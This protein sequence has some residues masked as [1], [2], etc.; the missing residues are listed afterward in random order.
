M[1]LIEVQSPRGRRF[2][3]DGV[4]ISRERCRDL[5]ARHDQDSFATRITGD[6]TRQ[7]SSLRPRVR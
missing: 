5:K 7:F 4:R 6:I 1:Q 3:L 2:Y